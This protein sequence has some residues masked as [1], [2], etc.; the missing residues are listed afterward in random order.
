M[1]T[2]MVAAILLMHRKGIMEHILISK[3]EWLTTEIVKRNWK[4]SGVSE[5]SGAAISV[6]KEFFFYLLKLIKKKI[7]Y[8]YVIF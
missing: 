6:R 3:V 8:Y 7:I 5:H 2:Y 1:P 4:V